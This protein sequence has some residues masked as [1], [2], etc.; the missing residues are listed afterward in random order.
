MDESGET[1]RLFSNDI[2]DLKAIADLFETGRFHLRQANLED[3][4]LKATG[5]T[6]NDRQ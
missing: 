5:R 4:F 6:L 1:A 2:D 3:V